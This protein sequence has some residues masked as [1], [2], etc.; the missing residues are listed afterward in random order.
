MNREKRVVLGFSGGVDS[1]AAAVLLKRQGYQVVPVALDLGGADSPFLLERAAKMAARLGLELLVEEASALFAEAVIDYLLFAYTHAQTPNPCIRCNALVKFA[2]L[3]AVAERLQIENLATGHYFRGLASAPGS[4]GPGCP[5][6]M[7]Y[8][9]GRDTRKNQSYFLFSVPEKILRRTLFPLGELT[10]DEA[11]TLAAAAGYD[12]DAYRESQELCFLSG[13]KYQEYLL[14]RGVDAGGGEIVNAQGRVMGQ[15]QGLQNY[16]IGQRR[17]MGI[18]HPTPLYVLELDYRHNRLLV[19]E[20]DEAYG[21]R[22]LVDNLNWLIKAPLQPLEIECQI[23]YRHQP[24]PALLTPLADGRVE[25]KFDEPQF[26]LT[27]GQG[28]A[29]HHGE[30]LLGGGIITL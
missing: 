3:A 5:E 2:R 25:V 9:Q 22:C 10:K 4:S 20:R 23:R 8:L 18:G 27:P 19:G 26:A 6:E 14:R 28:A 11:L 13:E 12:L 29:F 15:H 17:G 7:V 1:A 16:T 21:C 30:Y 24:A